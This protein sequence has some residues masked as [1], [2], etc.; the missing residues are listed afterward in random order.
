MSSCAGSRAGRLRSPARCRCWPGSSCRPSCSGMALAGSR[1]DRLRPPAPLV[2]NTALIGAL[3]SVV[4]VADGARGP[5]RAPAASSGAHAQ[6][7]AR[8][9]PGLR[10]ARGG[11][12]RRHPDHAGRLRPSGRPPAS[13]SSAPA[14]A[15]SWAARSVALIYGYLVRF[16]AVAYNPLEAGMA[17]IAPALEDAARI[18]GCRPVRPCRPRPPAAAA[19]QPARRRLLVFVEVMKE[20]PATMILRPSTSTRWRSRPSSSRPPSGWTPRRCR[21]W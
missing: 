13:A 6:P 1:R 16:F 12:R 18:L 19:R 8:R 21:R 17:K 20:L 14:P 4:I 10:R 3:A 11:D 2:G 9:K 15:W 7:A 5:A